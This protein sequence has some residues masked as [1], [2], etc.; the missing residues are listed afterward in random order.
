M[1]RGPRPEAQEEM[2]PPT[3]EQEERWPGVSRCPDLEAAANLEG[4]GKRLGAVNTR[5]PE[6]RLEGSRSL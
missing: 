6:V 5:E 4:S 1:N 2:E 3:D